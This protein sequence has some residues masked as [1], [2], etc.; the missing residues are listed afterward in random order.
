MSI[1]IGIPHLLFGMFSSTLTLS[2]TY[3]IMTMDT[4]LYGQVNSSISAFKINFIPYEISPE[5]IQ[6]SDN[7][8]SY[9]NNTIKMKAMSFNADTVQYYEQFFEY[10]GTHFFANAYT[11]GVFN[12]Q[13]QTDLYLLYDMNENSISLQAQASFYNFLILS[14]AVTGSKKDV[15]ANFTSM[16]TIIQSCKGGS[17]CPSSPTDYDEWQ[18]SVASTPWIISANFIPMNV[19]LYNDTVLSNN[20]AMAI[21]NHLQIGY[22]KDEILPNLEMVKQKIKYAI[23]TT[24]TYNETQLCSYPHYSDTE[25]TTNCQGNNGTC[26]KGSPFGYKAMYLSQN[27][28][29]QYV[30]N[31]LN[32]FVN[33]LYEIQQELM[34]D[35]DI[36][37]SNTNKL[38]QSA[39]I[40]NETMFNETAIKW[41]NIINSIQ[42]LPSWDICKW[43]NKDSCSNLNANKKHECHMGPCGN[44]KEN[45]DYGPCHDPVVFNVTYFSGLVTL[46]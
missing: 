31:D 4:R 42:T 43:I 12:L 39:L 44:S 24:S 7:A 6:L 37:E 1:S 18:L 40:V 23:N 9:I 17:F 2:K 45:K 30:E 8:M 26:C 38:L 15:N 41:E 11:G 29:H 13:Y 46:F 25:I 21:T 32:K 34:N 35:I 14:G 20:F 5:L 3:K 36:I 27:E 33:K 28:Y 19:L 22:L 16:T 10:F